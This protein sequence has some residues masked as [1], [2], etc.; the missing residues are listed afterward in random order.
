ML[1]LLLF[2]VAAFIMTNLTF[3]FSDV[4]LRYL[5][6]LELVNNNWQTLAVNY[7]ALPYDPELAHV[8]FYYA[9]SLL[10]ENIY[11][12]ISPFLPVM[13]SWFYALLGPAGLAVVPVAGTVLTAVAVYK[14]AT[15]TA[16]PHAKW[17]LWLTA[18]GTPMLFYTFELWDHTLA[19]ACAVWA[20]LGIT[21]A[22]IKQ[23][24]AAAFLG[25]I[26]LGFGLAQRP[27]MYVFAIA[28]GLAALLLFWRKWPVTVLFIG[29]SLAGVLPF[30]L[31]QYRWVGHPLGMGLATNLFDYGRPESYPVEPATLNISRSIIAGR[32]FIL[33]RSAD[34]VTFAAI[35]LILF[36]F[37]ITFLS[38]R[39]E[40][41]RTTRNLSIGLFCT[42]IGY[43][44]YAILAA[45]DIFL[46]GLITT[47]PL[48][49]LSLAA[50]PKK[51]DYGRYRA[52]Y[53]FVFLTFALFTLLMVLFWPASGGLQ[54]GARYLLPVIPL[55]IYL[56]AYDI[57][58]Y[59][60][61]M[62]GNTLRAFRRLTAGLVLMMV[63]IQLTGFKAQLAAHQDAHE[64]R[65]TIDNFPSAIILTNDPFVPSYMSELTD[66]TFIYV[67]DDDDLAEMVTRLAHHGV[68]SFS[69]H[70]A[71]DLPISIPDQIEQFKVQS[72]QDNAYLLEENYE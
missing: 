24:P 14:L 57:H 70:P 10:E 28:V 29:G 32:F 63:I 50:V 41:W 72:I 11:L 15:I 43:G 4:G 51:D 20:V 44:I 19:V 7:K 67:A 40:K 13:A 46:I 23:K 47:F 58:A 21:T 53:N 68:Y 27:E 6:V 35:L 3:F 66:K 37:I 1:S 64:I 55:L 31:L 17:A 59:E 22:V 36:G 42:L 52:I 8:P 38:L 65:D 69:V 56:A 16:L 18:I 5:Q 12:N 71:A 2:S 25:G 60:Q 34:V 62:A 26:A 30:W 39:Q 61:I 33:V 48:L 49:V 45:M 54:W 9:Y